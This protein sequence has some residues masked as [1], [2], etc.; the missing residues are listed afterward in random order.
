MNSG[1][2]FWTEGAP[3]RRWSDVTKLEK[4]FF[5]IRR[6]GKPR[7][8]WIF[9]AE[10]LDQN[11][12]TKLEER[13]KL[14]DI[15]K[16]KDKRRRERELI[17]G[18]QRKAA[19]YLEHE[20]DKDDILEWLAVMRH[21]GAPTRLLDWT[22]SFYIAVYLALNENEKG[23]VWALNVSSINKP[24]PIVKRICEE[25]DGFRQFS[26]VLL[27]Y[28]KQS[29]FLGIR[30]EGDKLID[31]AIASYLLEHS[32]PFPCVYPVNPFRLNK[33]L[34][35]QQGLFLMLGDVAKPFAENLVATLG[36]PDQTKTHLWRIEITPKDDDRKG[37]LTKLRDMNISNEA[38]LPGLDGFARSVGEGL[39]YP[40]LLGNGQE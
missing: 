13:F 32:S 34:S 20:P 18:F 24:E 8:K 27:H 10:R 7:P 37:I 36:G 14:N 16:V 6:V 11:L 19:L 25:A 38:L 4:K 21:H 29:D 3:V 31:L 39:A 23:V 9:R 12:K 26:K 5:P 40:R 17:R 15:K 2:S 22:Y 1:K 30:A 33:R 35:V 28:L